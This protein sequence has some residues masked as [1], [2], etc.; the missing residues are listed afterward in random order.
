[1]DDAKNILV[2][3]ISGIRFV[4]QLTA[5][6]YISKSNYKPDIILSASGGAVS[7]T[8][9]ISSN[10]EPDKILRNSQSLTS[11]F[12]VRSWVPD[13]LDVIPSW[14]VG[15]FQGSLYNHSNC[16]K[17]LFSEFLVESMLKDVEMW[18]LSYNIS[19]KIA[20][21]FC[22]TSEEKAFLKQCSDNCTLTR[23]NEFVFLDGDVE[24]FSDCVIASSSVPT[25]VPP[26]KIESSYYSDG[27]IMYASPFVPFRDQ[28]S[29]L[30]SFHILY[31][32][33][34]NLDDDDFSNKDPS[35]RSIVKTAD[36]A[37][38]ALV[39]SIIIQDRFSCFTL[40]Q[41]KGHLET[42]ELSFDE[43]LNEK[44]NWTYSLCEL[45]PIRINEIDITNFTGHE[46]YEKMIC[47]EKYIGV[48]VWYIEKI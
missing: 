14:F 36:K 34:Y 45:Y 17:K 12:F 10:F 3:P 16:Y 25:I 47:Q 5:M 6:L 2:A 4:N 32:N 39:K 11:D 42:K 1:M 48:R 35:D 9:A 19:D 7:S 13:F 29:E 31:I 27:G 28:I 43:Y 30:K 8:V 38:M 18:I 41:S 33:G 23:A 21:L 22:S 37:T 26:K 20:S 44:K 40:I 15:I 46:V 24:K